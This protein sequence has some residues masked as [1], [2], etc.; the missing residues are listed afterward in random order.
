MAPTPD[1]SKG[2]SITVWPL[3]RI[4]REND[5]GSSISGKSDTFLFKLAIS[6]HSPWRDIRNHFSR[7]LPL[8]EVAMEKMETKLVQTNRMAALLIDR[9]MHLLDLVFNKF[10]VECD[11]LFD[12][13]QFFYP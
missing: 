5:T 11:I 1:K 4:N 9:R 3:A 13:S 7:P 2:C 8:I 12:V 10:P 6:A